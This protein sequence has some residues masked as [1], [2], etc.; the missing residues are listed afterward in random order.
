[1]KNKSETKYLLNSFVAHVQTQFGKRIKVIRTDN[2]CEFNYKEFYDNLGI[3]HQNS[4][5]E[6]PQQNLVVERKHQHILNV[7]RCIMFHSNIPK[8]FWSYAIC[9]AV[10]IINRIPFAVMDFKIPYKLLY[11]RKLDMSVFKVFGCVCFASTITNNRNKFDSRSRKCIFLGFENGIKGYV[12][13]DVKTREI[14]ISRDVIFHEGTFIHLEN[15]TDQLISKENH[16]CLPFEN[17][18]NYISE[19]VQ[20]KEDVIQPED[21]TC[22]NGDM[23]IS[24]R[25][26]KAPE[27][28]KDYHHRISNSIKI[29][30]NKTQVKYPI[31]SALSYD[32]L[33]KNQLCLITYI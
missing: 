24:A 23:R 19:T 26:R 33:D 17:A 10:F 16:L 15:R 21:G 3:V 4:C 22:Q 13:L 12:F 18:S 28:L 31:S 20:P 32:H 9:H 6:T 29:D 5:I 7:A 27:Y 11:K 8:Q 30:S 25:L 14:F 1:M 2:G